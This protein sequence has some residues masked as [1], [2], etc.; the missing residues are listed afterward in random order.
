M[1]YQVLSV[2]GQHFNYFKLDDGHYFM[3]L[4]EQL[5]LKSVL[6]N[7]LNFLHPNFLSSSSLLKLKIANPE[8]VTQLFKLFSQL[9]C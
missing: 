2:D 3:P 6:F 1:T 7:Q 5:S 4:R 9:H 8:N